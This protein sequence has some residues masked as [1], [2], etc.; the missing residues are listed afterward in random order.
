M[1]YNDLKD[2]FESPDEEVEDEPDTA[3]DLEEEE[4]KR[5]KKK[6]KEKSEK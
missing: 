6:R 2:Q 5:T 4:K 3:L 1:L